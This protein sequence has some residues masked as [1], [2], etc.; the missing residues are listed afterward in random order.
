MAMAYAKPGKVFSGAAA[1]M[2]RWAQ[3]LGYDISSSG[4]DRGSRI[5]SFFT[6]T[7]LTFFPIIAPE[8][9]CVNQ[10]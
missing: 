3:I 8:T 10:I 6:Q 1:G 9:L 7:L 5:Q 4:A 2:P